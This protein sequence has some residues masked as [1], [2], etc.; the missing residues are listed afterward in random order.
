MSRK[1]HIGIP[2]AVVLAEGAVRRWGSLVGLGMCDGELSGAGESSWWS[3]RCGLGSRTSQEIGMKLWELGAVSSEVKGEIGIEGRAESGHRR[4]WSK[5][6]C[7]DCL[8]MRI[9]YIYTYLPVDIIQ[10]HRNAASLR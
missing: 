10:I 4:R 2:W 7:R 6:Q 3:G 8:C 1:R 9:A 5:C